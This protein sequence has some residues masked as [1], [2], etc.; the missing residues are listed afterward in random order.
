MSLRSDTTLS[1]Q[2]SDEG[3]AL[4][5]LVFVALSTSVEDIIVQEIERRHTLFQ[6]IYDQGPVFT[7]TNY[8]TLSFSPEGDFSW[9]GYSLLIPQII[10]TRV[11]GNGTIDMRLFL[12][13]TLTSP[14]TGAF[15]L[16]FNGIGG[17]PVPVNFMYTMDDQGFRIEYAPPEN[18]EGVTVTRRAGSPTV[19][20]FQRVETAPL[21]EF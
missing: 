15:T 16:V 12:S 19:I 7:S 18:L 14:Y 6:I 17:P 11:I 20:Y 3:G 10:P 2:Y 1:V 13:P 4:R 21:L 9:A 8:G 5:S